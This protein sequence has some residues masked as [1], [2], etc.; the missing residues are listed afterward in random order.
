MV[1]GDR[2]YTEVAVTK[3]VKDRANVE[4]VVR[5][6]HL[7]NALPMVRNASDA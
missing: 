5:I 6:T 7:G 1:A 3:V 4:I 2:D